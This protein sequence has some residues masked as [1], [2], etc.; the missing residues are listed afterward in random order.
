MQT[1]KYQDRNIKDLFVS[2]SN[3]P[4]SPQVPMVETIENNLRAALNI[5]Y[6]EVSNDSENHVGH[7]G[8]TDGESHFS[9]IVV[10]DDFIDKNRVARQRMVYSALKQEMKGAIHALSLKTLTLSEWDQ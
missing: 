6:I 3:T 4:D 9:I 5:G 8:Y 2:S 7:A 1:T 10:S